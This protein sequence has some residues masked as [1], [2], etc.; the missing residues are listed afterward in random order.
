MYVYL[1]F[2]HSVH[3]NLTPEHGNRNVYVNT[4][5]KL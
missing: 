4:F 2:K 1:K 3:S 5:D